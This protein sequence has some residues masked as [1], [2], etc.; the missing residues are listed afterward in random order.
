MAQGLLIPI[1]GT[2]VLWTASALAAIILAGILSAAS[3]SRS[4]LIRHPADAAMLLTRGVPTSL[5]VIVAGLAAMQYPAPAWLPNPFPGTS[6]AMA[7]VGW[8]VTIALALGSTGHL[9]VIFRAGYQSLGPSRLDQIAVLGLGARGRFRILVRESAKASLAPTGARL[10]H[11]LHN[12]G[13]AALFPVVDLFGWV[14][15]RSHE[16]FEVSRYAAI[17][18]TAYVALSL[19]IWATTRTAE[20]RLGSPR[21]ARLVPRLLPRPALGGRAGGAT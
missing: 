10:V 20:G 7:M 4:R 6:S 21:R 17:G 13:F 18:A 16:T 14:Q 5:L 12:T 11:H 19:V 15:Q 8:A 1:L 9:A 3:L 2:L